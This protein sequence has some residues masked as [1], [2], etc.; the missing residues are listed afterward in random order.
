[1]KANRCC[2]PHRRLR[3][4]PSEQQWLD[5]HAGNY[6]RR[7]LLEPS[8]TNKTGAA[9]ELTRGLAYSR[10]RHIPPEQY[11]LMPCAFTA[12]R[13]Q[14]AAQSLAPALRP[15]ALARLPVL[16][17][18]VGGFVAT[19]IFF[20]YLILFLGNLPDREATWIAPSADSGAPAEG[21]P[22]TPWLTNSLLL[23]IFALQHSGMARPSFKAW[24]SR[25]LPTAL[26]RTAYVYAAAAAGFLLLLLWQPI[27][28]AVWRV[29]DDIVR[30]LVWAAF[31]AGWL[32]LLAAALSIDMLELLGLKQCWAYWAL[33]PPPTPR[34]QTGALYGWL[35]HPM[36]VGLLLGMW[37][38][39]YM[40]AGHF[41][42]AVGLSVYI[43]VGM[44]LE[45]RDLRVRFGR[46]YAM[47]R[48]SRTA[49]HASHLRSAEK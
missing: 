15:N 49:V 11:G 21:A 45:E 42:L 25:H 8:G 14:E 6:C 47:W 48:N 46:S 1:M 27:P 26:Q 24:L 39:P 22:W 23:A 30:A 3:K 5:D 37:S 34:L 31:I 7:S 35:A 2:Q 10:G 17:A 18:G 20:I 16:L 40:T 4:R 9:P 41:Q 38:A 36:Y 13:Q 12:S 44:A 32:L 28:L 43:V 29:D 33:R 19:W